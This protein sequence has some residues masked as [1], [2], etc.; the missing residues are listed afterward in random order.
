MHQQGKFPLEEL[1][2]FYSIKN[3]EKALED[4]RTGAALKAVL[5]WDDQALLEKTCVNKL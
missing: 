1:V 4:S 2:T 3:Y 5:K